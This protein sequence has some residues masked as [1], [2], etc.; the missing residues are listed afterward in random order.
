MITSHKKSKQ[1]INPKPP[2]SPKS[3]AINKNNHDSQSRSRIQY[4]AKKF[5]EGKEAELLSI[6][7]LSTDFEEDSLSPSVLSYLKPLLHPL[8]DLTDN[9]NVD[10]CQYLESYIRDIESPEQD[11]THFDYLSQV[12]A[13]NNDSDS[14]INSPIDL[15]FTDLSSISSSPGTSSVSP[16]INHVK[17]KAHHLEKSFSFAQAA[18]V[19]QGSC[20]IYSKKVEYL[21]TLICDFSRIHAQYHHI[22]PEIANQ[23]KSDV[24]TPKSGKSSKLLNIDDHHHHKATTFRLIED[25]NIQNSPSTTSAD[26]V[27]FS[28][29]MHLP[30][31]IL[32]PPL[33]SLTP[34]LIESIV[35]KSTE[36]GIDIT[37]NNLMQT[38]IE[39]ILHNY[40]HPQKTIHDSMKKLV[41]Y[42]TDLG[43]VDEP[44]TLRDN[45]L[46]RGT[47]DNPSGWLL[48]PEHTTSSHHSILPT[49]HS[50][51]NVIKTRQNIIENSF[52][53][54]LISLPKV[55]DSIEEIYY[56]TSI[57]PNILFD[58]IP[59]ILPQENIEEILEY[60][61]PQ[62][63]TSLTTLSLPQE[64]IEEIL[65]YSNPQFD[66]SLTTLSPIEKIKDKFEDISNSKL[67]APL[68]QWS[69]RKRS[70]KYP[71]TH[72][73][74]NNL[75]AKRVKLVRGTDDVIEKSNDETTIGGNVDHFNID[76]D[77]EDI[78]EFSSETLFH[79]SSQP[80][81]LH[82][83]I[84]ENLQIN[85]D[86]RCSSYLDKAAHH[87]S[88]T[89][90]DHDASYESWESFI[91]NDVLGPGGWKSKKQKSIFNIVTD[92]ESILKCLE[93]DIL[94]SK[95]LTDTSINQPLLGLNVKPD[96]SAT[97]QPTLPF[98]SLIRRISTDNSDK[99]LSSL[100]P[101]LFFASLILADSH[102]VDIMSHSGDINKFNITL[103]NSERNYDKI[104][105]GMGNATTFSDV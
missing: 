103:I 49:N 55:T 9:W 26:H 7:H 96:K 101:R 104:K 100:I 33:T 70:V 38:I 56:T 25:S 72:Y 57:S 59:K 40:L 24:E 20:L 99:N 69:T 47:V 2:K 35:N 91:K 60:S 87:P 71:K 43:F 102:N 92:Q 88:N 11:I 105:K 78:L 34:T 1:S 66:T 76:V 94:P 32:P 12:D 79:N 44:N 82:S 75:G 52:I 8:R 81:I 36:D 68:S 22:N 6:S 23:T 80:D 10:I 28:C 15:T 19:L 39:R 41:Q 85:I 67:K 4:L 5:E 63:D 51:G 21:Y 16:S 89:I 77:T 73:K 13:I 17:R 61:N 31:L 14:H 64:N 29:P 46:T 30:V 58:T 50:Y 45:F 95:C 74:S 93:G 62:F 37:N 53:P 54:P 3:D 98:H 18:L 84:D 65:E 83:K 48:L 97:F 90:T 42:V 86:D 27:L